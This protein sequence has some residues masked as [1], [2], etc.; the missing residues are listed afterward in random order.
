MV[1]QQRPLF[2]NLE[3]E[4]TQ[5]T[6]TF[7]RPPLVSYTLSMPPQSS[8][9]TDQQQQSTS[10]SSKKT[11]KVVQVLRK[12]HDDQTHS[13][14]FVGAIVTAKVLNI[15]QRFAKC[16]ILAVESSL[17]AHEFGALLRKEDVRQTER[18]KVEIYKFY[19]PDDI[20]LARVTSQGTDSQA[21]FCISTAEDEL[22]V[23]SGRCSEHGHKLVPVSWAEM[24]CTVT[25]D[26]E[27][28]KVA[29]VPNLNAQLAKQNHD[30]KETP[31]KQTKKKK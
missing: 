14:P 27:P 7:T 23:V 20:I 13:C 3:K 5:R 2:T 28:R 29:K 17:L 15:G 9:E 19:R 25:G 1:V 21:P 11:C 30:E 8:N 4:R 10:S 16:S 31:G 12:P 6:G 22:G 18:D 24:E 26:R